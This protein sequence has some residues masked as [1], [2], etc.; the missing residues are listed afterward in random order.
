MAREDL[1][2]FQEGQSGNPNGRPRGSKSMKTILREMMELVIDTPNNEIAKQW[3]AKGNTIAQGK[4]TIKDALVMKDISNAMKGNDKAIQRVWE[5]LN[6]KPDQKQILDIQTPQ[7][8]EE[9]RAKLQSYADSHGMTLEEYCTR[10]GIDAP[11]IND[12]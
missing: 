5:Y 6:G 11:I 4:M 2:P 9:I 7:T 1:I 12:R 8:P 10:E 3:E